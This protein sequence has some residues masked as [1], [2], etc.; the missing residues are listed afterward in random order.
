MCT[1]VLSACPLLG[2]LSP[3][4]VSFVRVCNILKFFMHTTVEPNSVYVSDDPVPTAGLQWR[5][6]LNVARLRGSGVQL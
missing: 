2:G 4:G 6:M 3:F 1:R 5:R